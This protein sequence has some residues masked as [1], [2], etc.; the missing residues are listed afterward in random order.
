MAVFSDIV[1]CGFRDIYQA[2][3]GAYYHLHKGDWV[4]MKAVSSS[5]TSGQYLPD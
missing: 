5:E 1:L 4:I 2:F 3:R